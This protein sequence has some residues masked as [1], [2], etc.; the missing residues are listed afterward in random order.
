MKTPNK[1]LK[2]LT[3]SC[4]LLLIALAVGIKSNI[5]QRVLDYHV[6]DSRNHYLPCRKLPSES[7]VRAVVQAQQKLIQQIEQ[8]NPDGSNVYVVQNAECPEKADILIDYPGHQNRLEIEKLIDG[9]TFHGVP[10]RLQNY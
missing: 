10:Y 6:Y 9:D 8:V 5:P 7:E 3:I 2:V 1:S 4:S